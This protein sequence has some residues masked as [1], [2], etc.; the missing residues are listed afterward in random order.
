M[1]LRDLKKFVFKTS[2]NFRMLLGLT[3]QLLSHF[4]LN[5]FSQ[6]RLPFRLRRLNTFFNILL[7]FLQLT[8]G[9]LEFRIIG[10]QLIIVSLDN[11]SLFL[12][13]FHLLLFMLINSQL[14]L[15]NLFLLLNIWCWLCIYLLLKLS[16]LFTGIVGLLSWITFPFSIFIF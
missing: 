13:L 8:Y 16:N 1:L 12:S 10:L 5:L 14:H 2:L 11:G 6:L 3:C 15:G 7:L 9:I 4:L